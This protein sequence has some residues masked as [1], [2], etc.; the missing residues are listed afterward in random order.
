MFPKPKIKKKKALNNPKP[1]A[2]DVCMICSKPFA[3]THERFFGSG[4]R[5]LSIKYGMQVK[6]C[7]EHHMGS[8][9]PHHNKKFDDELKREGQMLFELYIGTREEFKTIFG[10]SYLEVA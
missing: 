7:Q 1:T 6:L 5:Q 10:R 3:H 8:M 9:G 4:Q 2:N